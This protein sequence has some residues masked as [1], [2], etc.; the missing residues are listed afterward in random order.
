MATTT[1][2]RLNKIAERRKIL[3][4]QQRAIECEKIKTIADLENGIKSLAPRIKELITVGVALLA[5]NIPFGNRVGFR[6]EYEEF[7]TNGIT[8]ELGFFFQ[9]GKHNSPLLG[10]GIKGGGCDGHDLAVNAEGEFVK[11]IDP[12]AKVYRY[13]GYYDY[14]RKCKQFIKDFDEFENKVYQY[15]EN[16]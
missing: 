13:D 1:T 10:I 7:I 16:L 6:K 4:T 11:A 8:H 15:V 12:Y 5:N 3:D 2:D 14:C 9:F